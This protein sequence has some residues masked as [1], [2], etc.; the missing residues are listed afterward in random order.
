[1]DLMPTDRE[2]LESLYRAF[3]TRDLET[4]LAGMH[5]DVDWPNGLEGGRVEGHSGVRE[6][7]TRQWAS[8]DSSAEPQGFSTDETGRTVVDVHLVIRDLNGNLLVDRMAQHVYEM[9]EGLV[10]RMEIKDA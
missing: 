8:V 5:P 10:L 6:Y 2:F 9:Q 4:A 7:W 1:M 3:N